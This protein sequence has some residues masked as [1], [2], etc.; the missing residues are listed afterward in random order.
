MKV[1]V[2]GGAG[3]IGNAIVRSLAGGGHR[4]TAAGRRTTRP[5]NL[6]DVDADYAAADLAQ[7]AEL[8]ALVSGHDV[9]VD[10]A[11]PYALNLFHTTT[12][13]DRHPVERAATRTAG[14]VHSVREHGAALVYIGTPRSL[15][16]NSA[17]AARSRFIRRL[18]P[19]FEVKQVIEQRILEAASRGLRTILLRPSACF[20]PWDIKPRAQC[21]LPALLRSEIPVV[22]QHRVNIVDTRDVADT[23]AHALHGA[24]YG[25]D[26]RVSGHNTSVADLFALVCELANVRP[27]RWS[28][29]A[30]LG[31]L[32][33]LSAEF[34]WALLG[35]PSPL[36][37]LVPMLLCE[38]E[39]ETA[40]STRTLRPLKDTARAAIDWYRK[41]GYC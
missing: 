17:S 27:P 39:W 29:P 34:G 23:L 2:L 3:L 15:S 16:G 37:S 19:Y 22:L 30:A 13:A 31:I 10:A 26:I 11:A 35:Q 12:S 6:V 41:L 1:L 8:D 32:P 28:V 38:Q 33:T 5:L 25:T 20:G 40:V 4:V 14:L 9:V 18:Q 21:W 24:D 36:P 7:T